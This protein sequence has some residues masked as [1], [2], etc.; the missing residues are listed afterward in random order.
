MA[1]RLSP[2]EL[3]ATLN[4]HLET[5]MFLVGPSITVADIVALTHLLPHWAALADYEKL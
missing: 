4:S 2:E 3:T 1:I 5:R